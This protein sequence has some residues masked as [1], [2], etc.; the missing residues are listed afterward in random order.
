VYLKTFKLFSEDEQPKAADLMVGTTLLDGEIVLT[1]GFYQTVVNRCLGI[2][3][4]NVG[5][6]EMLIE[7]L[8]TCLATAKQANAEAEQPVEARHVH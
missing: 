8:K 2:G 6:T 4:L 1:V 7:A 5:E 3:L